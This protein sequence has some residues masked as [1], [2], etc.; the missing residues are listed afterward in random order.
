MSTG[1]ATTTCAAPDRGEDTGDWDLPAL[2]APTEEQTALRRMLRDFFA[3]RWPEERLRAVA[4][5]ADGH[6]RELWQAM[7]GELGLHGLAVPEELGGGG[8]TYPDLLVVFEEMGRALVGGPFFASIAMASTL[9]L[10]LPD[11]D[12]Q[13]RLLPGVASGERIAT[14]AAVEHPTR[15]EA[16]DPVAAAAGTGAART[17]T[18]EKL[19]VLDAQV[20]DVLLAVVRTEHGTGVVEVDAAAPGVRIEPLQ[21]VDPTRRQARVVFESA[22]GTLLTPGHDAA[23]AVRRMCDLAGV[24]LAAEQVGG[25]TRVLEMA[26]SHARTREQFGRPIGGF[27]AVK[28]LLADQLVAVESARAALAYATTAAASEGATE[29]GT[30]VGLPV[31]AAAAQALCSEVFSAATEAN[32]HVHG[33]IGFTWEH[34]AHLYYRRAVSSEVMLGRPREHRARIAAHLVATSETP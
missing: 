34:P 3:E 6:D 30:G 16:G 12:A 9:L 28:H 19:F 7:A 2:L 21:T 1:R 32:I 18:G 4:G 29:T 10:A 5:S 22:P 25:A 23:P 26:T 27:Q 15:W 31:A 20:A 13:E 24:A 14:V 17:V 33:G 11:R 8:F